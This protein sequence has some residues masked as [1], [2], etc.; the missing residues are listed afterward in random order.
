MPE[1][2]SVSLHH[3]CLTAGAVDLKTAV[4]EGP[5]SP[6]QGSARW[7]S[8]KL[9]PNLPHQDPQMAKKL[10]SAEP[11]QHLVPGRIEVRP[12]LVSFA[13]L[14][15]R[16]LDKHIEV[17]VDADRDC[18]ALNAD[19]GGLEE[20]LIELAKNAS[21]AM[22]EGGRLILRASVE[23]QAGVE[24]TVLEVEHTGPDISALVLQNAVPPNSTTKEDSPLAGTGLPAVSAFIAQAGGQMSIASIEGGGTKVKLL[25]PSG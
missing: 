8:S 4:F 20:A 5:F 22:P 13:Q 11:R 14:M 7:S 24:T 16:A 6:T 1:K 21:W 12:F 19:P 18:P 3:S 23:R 9:E 2:D 17:V 25:L 15:R 10:R